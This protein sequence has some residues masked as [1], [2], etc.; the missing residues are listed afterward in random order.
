M[1]M[2]SGKYIPDLTLCKFSKLCGL[3]NA[4]LLFL[5]KKFSNFHQ[6]R[7]CGVY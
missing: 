6:S 5:K 2:E 7:L 3:S 1:Q 4:P